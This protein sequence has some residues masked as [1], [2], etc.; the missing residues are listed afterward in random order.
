LS[1]RRAS[2]Q[3]L[4]NEL[5]AYTLQHGD[6]AFIHQHVVDAFAAQHAT[7]ESKPIN[8]AFSLAGLY[9]HVEKGFSGRQVQR[10]HMQ[11]ARRKR[12]WPTFE[13]PRDRGT[14]TVVDVMGAP[15]GAGRDALIDTWCA[16]VWA[17]FASN[18]SALVDFLRP[19]G[20]A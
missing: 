10:A 5:C 7:R 6:P 16:S 18:R 15:A 12:T 11:L 9:L 14:V 8:V 13:L 2:E 1:T 4:Y 3:D 17:A 19:Y 20:L